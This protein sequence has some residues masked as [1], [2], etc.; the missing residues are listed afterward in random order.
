MKFSRLA[1]FFEELEGTSSRNRMVEILAD[2]LREA[3]PAEVDKLVYL[4]QGRLVPPFE[5]LE[6]GVGE[7]S[8]REALVAAGADAAQ[9]RARARAL[10]DYG[11]AA[12]E[13]L[14]SHEDGGL[15]VLEVYDLL[16][17]V[18]TASGK[19]SQAGKR[20]LLAQLL[21]K[22]GPLSAK[23]ALRIVLGRL[24]LGVGDPTFMDALSKWRV[25]DR[26]ERKLIERAYNLCSDLGVVAKSY[27]AEGA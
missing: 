10:G 2:L 19:G 27:V 6:F 25:D 7:A 16:Y 18:A 9:V 15:S 26:T 17:D 24:R 20:E 1:E 8:V 11:S 4:G 23:H 13:L 3:E 22:L 5:H 12:Q 21:Q 14:A